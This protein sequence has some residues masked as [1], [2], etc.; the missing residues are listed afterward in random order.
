M[1]R[2]MPR[3]PHM[4]VTG[5]HRGLRRMSIAYLDGYRQIM[6]L[7]TRCPD[8]GMQSARTRKQTDMYSVKFS[9]LPPW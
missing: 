5:L 8:V 1:P 2:P 9:R 4:A 7:S 3:T 6:R